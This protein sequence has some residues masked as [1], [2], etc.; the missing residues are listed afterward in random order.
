MIYI[1]HSS[2]LFI[3]DEIVIQMYFWFKVRDLNKF[4]TRPTLNLKGF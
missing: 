2:N 4:H 1:E 3:F